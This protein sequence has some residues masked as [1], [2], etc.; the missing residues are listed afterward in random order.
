[1]LHV[2]VV[3]KF[4]CHCSVSHMSL[5]LLLSLLSFLSLPLPFECGFIAVVVLPSRTWALRLLLW[6]TL[7]STQGSSHLFWSCLSL[8][9]LVLLLLVLLYLF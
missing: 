8:L 3:Q 9:L 6:Y 7:L 2:V 4:S 1:M 5:L